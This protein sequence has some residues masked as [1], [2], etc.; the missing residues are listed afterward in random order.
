LLVPVLFA[1]A[2]VLYGE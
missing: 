2:T 1:C